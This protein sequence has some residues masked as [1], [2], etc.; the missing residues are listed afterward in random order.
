[1]TG[2]ADE[3]WFAGL[4]RVDR[5]AAREAIETGTADT[6]RDWP[7]LAVEAGVAADEA[8]YYDALHEAIV[9]A[10][11]QAVQER[12]RADDQQLIHAVRALDDMARI[13]L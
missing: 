8:D 5:E 4:D 7:A 13:L 2:T 1:M 6:P 11:R 9:H 12:E 10:T 3:G